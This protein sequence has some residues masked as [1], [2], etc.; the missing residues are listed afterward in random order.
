[1]LN[2]DL[3]LSMNA[4]E[5]ESFPDE[6]VKL[7]FGLSNEVGTLSSQRDGRNCKGGY[8]RCDSRPNWI[9]CTETNTWVCDY[10]RKNGFPLRSWL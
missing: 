3:V 2:H 10:S 4:A 7:E 8:R 9:S 5:T 1:M 6:V